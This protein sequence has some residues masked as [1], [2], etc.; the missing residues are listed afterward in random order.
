MQTLIAQSLSQDR[1]FNLLPVAMTSPKHR[2]TRINIGDTNILLHDYCPFDLRNSGVI[3]VDFTKPQAVVGNVVTYTQLG[4]PFVMGTSLGEHEEEVRELVQNSQISA[5][6]APNM[7]MGVVERQINIDEFAQSHPG[8]FEGATIEI[9]ESHQA[10]KVDSQT[11]EPI[12]SATARAF[13]AQ[14]ERHGA[15]LRGEIVSIRDPQKQIDLGVPEEFL[16]GHGY[17]WVTAFGPNGEIIYQ[18]ETRIN[19]RGS[20]VEGTVVGIPFL[21][22]EAANGSRGEIF[23][24]RDVVEDIRRAA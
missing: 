20:Y 17:H 4:I 2:R 15:R 13:Q 5:L 3:A 8:I 19:G 22:R 6:I 11:H 12:V 7:D 10:S 1:R 23:G 21:S 16:D 24:M 9:T 18:F 14:M